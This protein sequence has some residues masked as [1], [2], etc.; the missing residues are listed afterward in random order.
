MKKVLL[1]FDI[2]TEIDDAIALA[3][4]LAN[5]E[6]ELVGI[7]TSCG[8]SIKRAEMASV[9]CRAAGKKVPIHAGCERPLL[10]PQMETTAPQAAILPHYEHDTGFAPNT[11]IPFMQKVIR[12]NPGE[13]TLL[14]VAPMTNLGLLFAMDPELPELLDGLYLLC[15]S[16]THQ[17]HDVVTESLSAMERDDFIRVLASQGILE[18][19]SIVDPHATSIVYR[20]RCRNFVNIGNNVSSRVVMTPEEAERRFR[21]PIMQV[22]MS[23]AR[24]WFKDEPRVSFHDPLAAV[25]IFNDDVCSYKRGYMDCV[26]DSRLLGGMTIFREDPAGPHQVAW[27]VDGDKFFE[28]LFEV[29]A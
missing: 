27:D 1:D 7:T 10:I 17:R 21:H 16:P 6:C 3:Y 14:A 23:I 15:G 12:E 8:E 20:A 13:V 18:N 22:V 24:E 4:L 9:L 19:N 29:F 2:G 25:C 28:H 5:P 11:A 26:L